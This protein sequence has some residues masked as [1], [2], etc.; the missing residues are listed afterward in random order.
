MEG[1][2][3]KVGLGDVRALTRSIVAHNE[4]GEDC[5][6]EGTCIVENRKT[7]NVGPCHRKD[8]RRILRS[9]D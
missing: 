9:R 1:V 7:Q 3:P 5:G 6:R 8:G 2:L 4:I